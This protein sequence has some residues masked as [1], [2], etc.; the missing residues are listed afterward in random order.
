M[1]SVQAIHERA[2]GFFSRKKKTRPGHRTE[3]RPRG[4][5]RTRIL[6]APVAY[7]LFRKVRSA[8]GEPH[9]RNG[10][11]NQSRSAADGAWF[12]RFRNGLFSAVGST[13]ADLSAPAPRA[14]NRRN[15]SG[16]MTDIQITEKPY[17]V[18]GHDARLFLLNGKDSFQ[19]EVYEGYYSAAWSSTELLSAL[20]TGLAPLL[21]RPAGTAMLIGPSGELDEHSMAQA[22]EVLHADPE[23][24]DFVR[25][26]YPDRTFTW[27]AAER[28]GQSAQFGFIGA[29]FD[30]EYGAALLHATGTEA[31]VA[32]ADT[33]LAKVAALLEP[34]H[35]RIPLRG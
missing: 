32:T 12:A 5:G 4:S 31:V 6:A 9:N 18:A 29:A 30:P 22:L 2:A 19:V 13:G 15:G 1:N 24:F 7:A 35:A 17:D 34:F 16:L 20:L 28:T 21:P 3:R 23:G 10:D 14:D 27:Q 26:D 33:L 11:G 25:F 8:S